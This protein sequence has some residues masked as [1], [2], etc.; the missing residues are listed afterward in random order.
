MRL[1]S[2]R[3]ALLCCLSPH[4]GSRSC[5]SLTRSAPVPGYGHTCSYRC[6]KLK[7]FAGSHTARVVNVGVQ[8]ASCLVADITVALEDTES[9]L[10]CRETR[11]GSGVRF[12]QDEVDEIPQE[13]K[14][15]R[16]QC[17]EFPDC[18]NFCLMAVCATLTRPMGCLT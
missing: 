7:Q 4:W 3:Q 16:R 14:L 11:V 6:S 2:T 17:C 15:P 18:H 13:P 12:Q 10:Q 1:C 5:L 9:A 8:M